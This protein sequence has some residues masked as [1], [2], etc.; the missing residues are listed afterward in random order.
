MKDYLEHTSDVEVVVYGN[1]LQ[2]L[3]VNS[4]KSM[5]NILK[6][7]SCDDVD[8]YDCSMKIETKSKDSTCLLIDF[9]SEVLSLSYVHKTIFCYAYFSEITEN[10]IDAQLYGIWFDQF[11]EEIKGVTYHEADVRRNEN[12]I[13]ET[14]IIFDL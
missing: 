13:W 8:H 2:E 9:L 6:E 10:K 14:H 1:T 3:F 5:N 4:L 7:G 11:D 12:N